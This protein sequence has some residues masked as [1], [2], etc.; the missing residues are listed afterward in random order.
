MY[1]LTDRP[2]PAVIIQHALADER[3]GLVAMHTEGQ[4]VG[5]VGSHLVLG[6]T[7]AAQVNDIPKQKTARSSMSLSYY[8]KT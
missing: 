5:R 8:S 6:P 1:L 3:A 7:A 2:D 4:P